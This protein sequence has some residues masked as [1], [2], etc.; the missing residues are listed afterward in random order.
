MASELRSLL[1]GKVR[2][3]FFAARQALAVSLQCS[4][5]CAFAFLSNLASADLKLKQELKDGS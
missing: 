4:F 3:C 1:S 5:L 2:R